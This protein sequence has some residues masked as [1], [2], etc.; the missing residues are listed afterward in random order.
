[1]L[2]RK[3]FRVGGFTHTGATHLCETR[4]LGQNSYVRTRDYVYYGDANCR[5]VHCVLCA[6]GYLRSATCFVLSRLG[7]VRVRVSLEDLN[8]IPPPDAPSDA[9]GPVVEFLPS[10]VLEQV[11]PAYQDN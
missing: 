8:V 4:G 11:R 6:S 7:A 2:T 9:P 3:A 1:M 10:E 5:L